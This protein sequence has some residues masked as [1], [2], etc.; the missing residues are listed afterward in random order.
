MCEKPLK[1]QPNQRLDSHTIVLPREWWGDRTA[2]V[3]ICSLK[4]TFI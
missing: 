4:F 3:M 1:R 2:E